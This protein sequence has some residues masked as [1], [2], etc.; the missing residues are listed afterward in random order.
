[1]SA[2]AAIAEARSL[3]ATGASPSE[4]ARSVAQDSGVSRRVIYQALIDQDG[5]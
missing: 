1:M 4:A 2:E 5:S 3:I